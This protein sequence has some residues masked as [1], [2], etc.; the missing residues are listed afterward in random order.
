MHL[1]GWLAR[2]MHLKHAPRLR[3]VTDETFAHAAHIDRLLREARRPS[4]D[5]EGDD[6]AA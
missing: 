6:G 3:F 5:E 4:R 1:G 2:Q